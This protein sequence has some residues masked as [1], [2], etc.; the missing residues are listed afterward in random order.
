MNGEEAALY[1]RM[2]SLPFWG[3]VAFLRI[4]IYRERFRREL[5]RL[6]PDGFLNVIRAW[7]NISRGVPVS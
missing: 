4:E 1:K 7:L 3:S 2:A 6:F 5:P